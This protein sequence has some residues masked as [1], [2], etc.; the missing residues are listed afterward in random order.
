M[1]VSQ[2]RSA[3]PNILVLGGTTEASALAQA[4]ADAG[5]PAVLS[6]AGRVARPRAQPLPVRIGGFGGASGLATYLGRQGITHLVD[7]THPFAATI[8]A[9][10]IAAARMAGVPLTVFT[11]APWRPGPGDRWSRVPDLDAALVALEGA[12]RRV[13]LAIGRQNL[14]AFAAQPQHH[15]I[16]RLV[17]P[18]VDP[19]LLPHHDVIIDRGPFTIA[20]DL[21]MMRK[22]RVDLLLCKNSGGSG[23]RAKLDAARELRLPVVMIDRPE[24]PPR[25]E[26][27]RLA[28]VMARIAHADLGV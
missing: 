16:L 3:M 12:A 2:G 23:A 27:T 17:D 25:H 14:L 15:Y 4:L 7:A 6:Y 13:L 28:D 9:N 26:V 5:I 24:M 21:D 19:P 20:G 10:A 8:S 18:P 11:R 1:I 22:H